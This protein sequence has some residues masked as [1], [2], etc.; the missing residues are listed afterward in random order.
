MNRRR[1][2][3][4]KLLLLAF[5]TTTGLVAS[6]APG[7]ATETSPTPPLS[8]TR[9]AAPAGTPTGDDPDD[10][11]IS[12]SSWGKKTK[13][14]PDDDSGSRSR[15]RSD[16]DEDDSD[17]Y[18]DRYSDDYADDEGDDDAIAD[19]KSKKSDQK[20]S[21]KS[22]KKSKKSKKKSSA[23]KSSAKKK[24]AAKKAAKKKDAARK[25]AAAR[26]RAQAIK[27]ARQAAARE[28]A[29]KRA[30]QQRRATADDDED[31][32]GSGGSVDSLRAAIL[33]L[34]NK[35]RASAGCKSSLRYSTQLERSAQSH[36]NDMS[37][38]NYMSHSSRSGKNSDQRIRQTGFDGDKTGENLGNGFSSPEGVFRAWMNSPSHRRNILDCGFRILGVGYASSG[39]YWVQHFG[40]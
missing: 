30:Q 6:A 25:K 7:L 39:G 20:K 26:M 33:K 10:D 27:A 3:P 36:A 40:G 11:E 5:L 31:S 29:Q 34:T 8:A 4:G 22:S 19:R 12:S 37:R 21:V 13:G 32:G 38:H 1:T 16:D 17:R 28:A 18:S 35:A 23:A 2:A 14:D 24:A 15:S 9:V